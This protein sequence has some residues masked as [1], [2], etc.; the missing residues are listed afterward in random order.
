MNEKFLQVF[1]RF[2]IAG[3]FAGVLLGVFIADVRADQA[4]NRDEHTL[5]LQRVTGIENVIGQLLMSQ[6][7]MVYLQR[8]Q[9]INTAR[10]ADDRE[11]CA[12]DRED[13]P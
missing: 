10:T 4:K 1:L 5:I 7:R 11:K 6:E 2:G 8:R 3:I 12:L 9:C 13:R